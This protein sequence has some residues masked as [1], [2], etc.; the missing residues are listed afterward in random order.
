MVP[1]S[2]VELSTMPFGSLAFLGTILLQTALA[3]LLTTLVGYVYY[4]R[5]SLPYLL[6]FIG[7]TT[8]LVDA[9]IGIAG[10]LISISPVV[11]LLLDHSLDIVLLMMVFGAVHTARRIERQGELDSSAGPSNE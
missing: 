6:L 8:L 2:P 7:T 5:R 11:H 4:Q 10:L 9:V 1:L 3:A